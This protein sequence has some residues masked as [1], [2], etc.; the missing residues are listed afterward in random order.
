MS[1]AKDLALKPSR[2]QTILVVRDVNYWGIEDNPKS[3]V[4]VYE[5]KQ[6]WLMRLDENLVVA[7]PS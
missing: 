2:I 1:F 7:R 3:Y 5:S 6:G 4:I